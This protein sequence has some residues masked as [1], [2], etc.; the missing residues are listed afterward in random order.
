MGLLL[1]LKKGDTAFKSLKYGN[2]RP[3]GGD[4]GQPFIKSPIPEDSKDQSAFDIDGFVRGGILAPVEA[5]TD[6]ARVSKYL[7]NTKNPSGLLFTAKQNILSRIA[8]KTE[9]AQGPAYGMGAVNDGIYTPLSTIAQVGVGFLG[10]HLNK[11]GLDPTGLFPAASINKYENIVYNKNV[12]EKNTLPDY[13]LRRLQQEQN[14]STDPQI[15]TPTS[16]Q[17][18]SN[19]ESTGRFTDYGNITPNASG[20]EQSFTFGTEEVSAPKTVLTNRLLKLWDDKGLNLKDPKDTVRDSNVLVYGGGPNSIL[21]IGQTNI[22]FATLN[23]GTTPSRTGKNKLDP[24]SKSGYVNYGKLWTRGET[25]SGIT[26]NSSEIYKEGA[27]KRYIESTY[28]VGSETLLRNRTNLSTLYPDPTIQGYYKR[29]DFFP[30][31]FD[32]TKLEGSAE[33]INF[34]P[35]ADTQPPT[36][37]VSSINQ[38][39]FES[40]YKEADQESKF[41]HPAYAKTRSE[42]DK[43]KPGR[44]KSIRHE[45]RV[46]TGDPGKTPGNYNEILDIVNGSRVDDPLLG[47]ARGLNDFVQFRIKIRGGGHMKFRALIDNMSDAYSSKWDNIEYMGVGETFK[48]YTGF[49]RVINLGFTVVAMSQAEM[50]GMYDKLRELAS[51]V[52]PK[53][54]AA[55]FMTGNI[56]ELTVGDYVKNQPGILESFTYDIPEEASWELRI[57]KGDEIKDELPMMIKV[58]GFTFTPI[59]RTKASSSN[60]RF[61]THDIRSTPPK[62]KK[63]K[64][65]KSSTNNA[66]E[67]VPVDNG[68]GGIYYKREGD[69]FFSDAQGRDVNKISEP[70]YQTVQT[71]TGT[72]FKQT[73]INI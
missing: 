71:A 41:L 34:Q 58:T 30:S 65:K 26:Y 22:K 32:L 45:I 50:Y 11:Q 67:G 57:G 13:P 66:P 64:E 61:I 38:K 20:I 16:E 8:P 15:D 21:G 72:I 14:I 35:W 46:K 1:K 63:D 24:Y 42:E 53:Y 43:I 68:A 55:G 7:F 47:V 36:P 23:D 49:N 9:T 2:D 40:Y 4:S 73:N 28:N 51:S 54:S 33:L 56:V 10:T 6:V 60:K 48:K 44:F 62:P 59:Y 69:K 12:K 27:T 19:F 31:T 39:L 70:S 18:F 3:G 25:I 52:A 37:T 29:S 5:A 17:A